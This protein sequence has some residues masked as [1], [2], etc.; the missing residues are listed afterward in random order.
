MFGL[1]ISE[2]AL[3]LVGIS[4]P[5]MYEPDEH[6][7][8][9]LMPGFRGYSSKE[10]AA[11]V[12][13]NQFGFRDREWSIEKPAGTFRIAVIGDSYIEA[14]QVEREDMFGVVLERELNQSRTAAQPVVEVLNFGVSGWGT[15]QALQALRHHVWQFSP[16]MVLL[17]FTFG[18]DVRNNSRR[19]E[20]TDCRPFFDL[21]DGELKLDTAFRQHP[22]YLYG[23]RPTTRTKAQIINSS[24]LLQVVQR[25]RQGWAERAKPM[26]RAQGQELGLD[27]EVFRAPTSPEWKEAW[28]L[29]DRL[30]LEMHREVA[31]RGKQFVVMTVTSGV[32]V[33]RD[34]A[35]R[36]AAAKRL[37]VEDLLYP[38]RHLGALAKTAGF[39]A[40]LLG[41][42]LGAWSTEHNEFVHGFHNTAPGSGHWNVAGHRE[43]AR[44]VAAALREQVR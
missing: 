26:I 44:I 1:A 40:I 9:R 41:E 43:A 5:Q 23:L 6:C 32:Q 14:A 13:V 19:L 27:D 8:S 33:H 3:R 18:N 35:V 37:G 12:E 15:A 22:S 38:D 28:E 4:N 39:K 31:E 2:V 11:H 42:P 34:Q 36:D 17:A 20:P 29:T 21:V 24:R 16:D 7:A 10:G 25:V 30:M